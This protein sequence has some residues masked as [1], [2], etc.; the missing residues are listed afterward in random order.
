M[1]NRLKEEARKLLN[2]GKVDFIIGFGKGTVKF[3]TAPLIT[4]KEGDLENLVIN[5]FIMNNLSR[6]LTEING[7]AGIVVK[8]CDSRSLVSLIQDNKVNRDDVVIL[9]VPCDG[10]VDIQKLQDQIGSEIERVAEI[11][12]EGENLIVH[13]DGSKKSVSFRDVI[14]DKCLGCGYPTPLEYDILLGSE[15]SPRLELERSL[16]KIRKL[17]DMESSERW[18]YWREQFSKCIRCYACRN[19]CPACFCERCFIDV[20]IPQWVSPYASWQ[21]NLVFQ[22]IRTLHVAGRCSDCGECERAC[23]VGIPLRSLQR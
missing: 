22:L 15:I 11:E 23:P 19:I 18:K 2:E 8:G 9:G 20:N 21:D 12:R 13:M 16:E 10:V 5:P 1:E 7:R 17:D 14:L 3:R 6:Y 4:N